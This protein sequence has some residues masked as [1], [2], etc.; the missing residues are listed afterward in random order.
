MPNFRVVNIRDGL[1]WSND[2]GWV[3][4]DNATIF[5]DWEV[6]ALALPIDGKW[7]YVSDF[8][9]DNHSD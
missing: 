7:E 6:L 8:V 4:S 1:Y 5:R 9:N 2:I 3:N